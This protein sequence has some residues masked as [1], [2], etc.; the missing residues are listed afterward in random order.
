MK[1]KLVALAIVAVVALLISSQLVERNKS[2]NPSTATSYEVLNC[3]SFGEYRNYYVFDENSKTIYAFVTVNCG[4]D[5]VLVQ[6][7]DGKIKIVERDYDGLLMR[8]VCQKEVRVYNVSDSVVE[9]VNW[10]NESIKL[11]KGEAIDA[12]GFCGF[13]TFAECKEDSDCKIG[14][15][16]GEVCMGVKE[17]IFTICIYRD[18][19]DRIK[20]NVSCKCVN[21]KCR[22]V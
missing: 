11:E 9:F 17:D 7:E 4:S 14:G 20:F 2:S 6:K 12:G 8:C 18:C 5:E 10:G 22:W 13:S 3:S 15:C 19:Y 1:K 16:S 21:N